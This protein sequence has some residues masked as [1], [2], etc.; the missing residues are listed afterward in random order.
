MKRR[1]GMEGLSALVMRVYPGKSKE[2]LETVR[3]FSVWV[4]TMSVRI[5][6]NARPVRLSRGVLTVHTTNGAWASSLSLESEALLAKLQRK[7]PRGSLRKLV[8]RPGPMPDAEA[9]LPPDPESE[10]STPAEE[11]PEEIAR[12]LARIQSDSVRTAV[13]KAASAG[14]GRPG[15]KKKP[16]GH[17][18]P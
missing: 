9:P 1:G 8:F 16:T 2:E 10:P 7:A 3:V 5:V 18:L 17:R 15:A 6:K 14:L 13:A 11:L 4:K 12:E